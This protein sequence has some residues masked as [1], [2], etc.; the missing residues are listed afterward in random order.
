M[1]HVDPMCPAQVPDML[2]TELRFDGITKDVKVH[3]CPVK[4]LVRYY[5]PMVRY[6]YCNVLACCNSL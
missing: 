1:Q 3:V 5:T 6:R 4:T 2:I